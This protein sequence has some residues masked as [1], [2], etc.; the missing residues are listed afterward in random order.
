MSG[1]QAA[2]ISPRRI[3]LSRGASIQS[4]RGIDA[5]PFQRTPL[6]PAAARPPKDRRQRRTGG[7]C[8]AAPHAVNTTAGFAVEPL[9]GGGIF[10]R[11]E[12]TG[13]MKYRICVPRIGASPATN[14]TISPG[15]VM[16]PD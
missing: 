14:T 7:E 9:A 12:N 8:P 16:R 15:A 3:A 4:P 6:A 5:E 11:A 13:S 10:A 2:T 1:G